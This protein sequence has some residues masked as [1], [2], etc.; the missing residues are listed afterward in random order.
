DASTTFR[1]RKRLFNLP[2]SGWSDFSPEL[3]SKGGGVFSR[4]AKSIP[5]SK[6]VR[7]WLG[8]EAREMAPSDLIKQLLMSEVDL[9]WNGGIGTYVKSASESHADVGDAQNN[10]LRVNG[11]DMRCKVIGEGGNLGM[12]QLGR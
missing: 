8:V 1:E 12:T 2:R 7:N 5:L 11:G 3:I 6:E 4:A 10:L 9:I